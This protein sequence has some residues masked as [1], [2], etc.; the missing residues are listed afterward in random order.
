CHA[1][2]CPMCH[3]RRSIVYRTRVLEYLPQTLSEH[4]NSRLVYLTLT[5]PNIHVESLRE[6]LKGMNKEWNKF[7]QRKEFRTVSGW[8]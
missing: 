7:T 1:R 6:S 4:P 2:H 3:M 5:V 8:I